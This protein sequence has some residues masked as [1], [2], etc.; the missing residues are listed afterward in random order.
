MAGVL[1]VVCIPRENYEKIISNKRQSTED[2][3]FETQE[4]AFNNDV[5]HS[6]SSI[7]LQVSH[8]KLLTNHK[9]YLY[10]FYS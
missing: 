3:E 6:S 7:S 8:T 2:E 1:F 4:K 10:D 9:Q 5:Y